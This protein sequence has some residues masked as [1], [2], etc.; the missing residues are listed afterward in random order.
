VVATIV[1]SRPPYPKLF[2]P[3]LLLSITD[4]SS[5]RLVEYGRFEKAIVDSGVFRVFHRDSRVEYPGGYRYWIDRVASFWHYVS[6]YG[7]AYA[8]VPD[9][10][11]DYPHNPISD[12]I[13]RTVRNIEYAL[14]KYPE[15]NWVVPVQGKPESVSSVVSTIHLLK[16]RGLLR[17]SYV[18][19]APTCVTK[20]PRFL[21]KLAVAARAHL[22][23]YRVHMFGVTRRAWSLIERYV[24]S[25]DSIIYSHY[26]RELL[27]RMCT[28]TEEHLFGWKAFLE[29]LRR[30]GYLS[31][32]DY[33]RSLPRW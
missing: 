22:P 21:Q 3:Y 17:G 15:V 18:A 29:D 16:Q 27:G 30:R 11:A 1:F 9:Y 6:K 7:E 31:E 19:I 12:N 4:S 25:I 28:T 10:P 24:D 13:E 2:Y 8:V 5:A 14:D 23:N 33:K 20:S 26:C 32:E